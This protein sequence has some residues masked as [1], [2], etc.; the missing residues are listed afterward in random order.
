MWAAN[1]QFEAV[2][3][4]LQQYV[5]F[6]S[7]TVIDEEMLKLGIRFLVSEGVFSLAEFKAEFARATNTICPVE[8]LPN[9]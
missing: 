6:P 1:E 4:F 5:S 3:Q 2:K 9:E 7:G 8:F